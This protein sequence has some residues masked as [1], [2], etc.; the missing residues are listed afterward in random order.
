MHIC[1]ISHLTNAGQT[2]RTVEAF[3]CTGTG[4]YVSLQIKA[5]GGPLS[6]CEVVVSA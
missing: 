6:L 1:C 5:G 3:P 4:R 2:Y